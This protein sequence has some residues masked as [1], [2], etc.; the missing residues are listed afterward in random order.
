MDKIRLAEALNE[1]YEDSQVLEF[2]ESE[3]ATA[4]R[5]LDPRND[6]PASIEFSAG[7]AFEHLNT[8]RAALKSYKLKHGR[9]NTTTIL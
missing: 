7:V 2:V 3:I 6:S 1:N 4:A 8:A 9:Q 5:C